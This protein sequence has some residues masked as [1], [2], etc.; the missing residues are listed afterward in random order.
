MEDGIENYRTTLYDRLEEEKK[1]LY[2]SSDFFITHNKNNAIKFSNETK[3]IIQI[4]IC[5]DKDVFI[6]TGNVILP[7]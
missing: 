4:F 7:Q 6:N 1:Y 5:N 2:V 3:K